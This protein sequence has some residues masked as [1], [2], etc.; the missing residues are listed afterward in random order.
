MQAHYSINYS[1]NLGA[2]HSSIRVA[3]VH[4]IP[5]MVV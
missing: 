4:S 1:I 5:F 3:P 2:E